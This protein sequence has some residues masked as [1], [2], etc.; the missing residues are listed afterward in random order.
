MK[1][2]DQRA[3][4][5]I[6]R[7]N[8]IAGGIGTIAAAATISAGAQTPGSTPQASPAASPAAPPAA[9]PIATPVADYLL[10]I[11]HASELPDDGSPVKGG[12]LRLPVAE[13]DLLTFVPTLQVQDPQVAWSYLDPLVRIDPDTMTPAASLATSWEISPDGLQLDFAL[14]NDVSWHDGT[15][16]TTEDARFTHLVYRDD[17]RS[18]VAGQS[19]LVTDI[20]AVNDTTLRVQFDQPDAAWLFNVASLPVIQR[21]QYASWWERNPVGERTLE[22]ISFTDS[23]PFGTGPWVVERA[24]D[25]G[26]AFV[27][28]GDYFDTPPHADRLELTPVSDA[29]ERIAMWK[30]GELNVVGPIEPQQVENVLDEEGRLVV[31]DAPRVVFGAFNFD[32]V[33][34]W[35]PALLSDPDVR[36]AVNLTLDRE[37]YAEEIWGGFLRFESTGVVPQTWAH[38]DADRNPDQDIERARRLMEEAGWQDTTGDDILES[39]AG[40][41]FVLTTL[42][43]DPP[44]PSVVA[45]LDAMHEDLRKIGG[46]LAI[47]IVPVDRFRTWWSEERTWDLIVYDLRLYPAFAEFD[48]IGSVWDS[49][50]NPAGWNPGAYIN[51]DADAA[52]ESYFGAT[53]E[54]AMA[55][56]LSD[57]QSAINDDLFALWLGFPQDLVLLAPNVRGYRPNPLWPTLDTRLM[58]I[59]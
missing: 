6:N 39:P 57:L 48:L 15:P 30:S 18:V 4:R 5:G 17:Y 29:D 51:P 19:A 47:N 50:T 42:V 45:T 21:A 54:N 10:D 43:L 49:R 31:S 16:F 12:T 9:T 56:A 53:D 52:I 1:A 3:G 59:E 46:A 44:S 25:D 55:A 14:R 35:E 34:R 22:G 13:T 2:S 41:A 37:R 26:V 33:G 32:N 20:I 27:R 8:V 36:E 40:D 24:A 28:N 7:R 38:S 11:Y 58:W 23:L